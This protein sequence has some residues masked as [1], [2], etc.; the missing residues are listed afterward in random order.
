M[1][2]VRLPLMYEVAVFPSSS[3]NFSSSPY[4]PPKQ[5][6][7]NE[8]SKVLVL[9][10]QFSELFGNLMLSFEFSQP[11]GGVSSTSH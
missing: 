2:N 9:F 11:D 1:E 10:H 4:L 5:K 8:S 6:Q 3:R 7:R